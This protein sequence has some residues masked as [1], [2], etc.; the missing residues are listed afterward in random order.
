MIKNLFDI[1]I[2]HFQDLESVDKNEC[3]QADIITIDNKVKN[4]IYHSL[5]MRWKGKLNGVDTPT[6]LIRSKKERKAIT[7]NYALF[8]EMGYTF[9]TKPLTEELYLEFKDIYEKTTQ[10]KERA[11]AIDLEDQLLAKIKINRPSYLIGMY[12]DGQIESGLTFYQL[13]KNIYVTLGAKK[14]FPELRGGVGG[15][16]EVELMKKALELDVEAI[17]HGKTMNP[18]GIT[19]SAGIFEFKARYGY[20]AYPEDSWQTMFIR[21]PSVALSD[22]VFVTTVDNALGYLVVSDKDPH[23]LTKRYQTHDVHSIVV[24]TTQEVVADSEAFINTLP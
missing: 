1:T 21:N 15:I 2:A 3:L 18:A 6:G 20:S 5:S 24:K 14:K 22:L 12:K 19:G 17:Y 11:L 23:E 4:G 8:H 16:L 10:Q 7:E 13:K 9:E